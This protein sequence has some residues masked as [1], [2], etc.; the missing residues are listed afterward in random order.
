MDNKSIQQEITETTV[1]CPKCKSSNLRLIELWK[2]H[3]IFWQQL[4]GKIDRNKGY[5]ESGDP[6]KIQA[7]CYKCEHVWTV[8]G[9][10]QIT[11]VLK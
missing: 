6:Y 9:A 4:G 8:R 11:N 7:E 1:R 10:T 3:G 2:D 5:I